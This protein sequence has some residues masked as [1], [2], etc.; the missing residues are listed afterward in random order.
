MP[1]SWYKQAYLQGSDCE[2]ITL[3]KLLA[4]LS[5]WKFLSLFTKMQY[6]LLIKN[7]PGQTPTVLVTTGI[8]E[9][10]THL[11]GLVPGRVRAMASAENEMQISR[12]AK[13]KPVSSRTPDILQNNV[14]SWETLGISTLIVDLQR[15][16]G[17]T[18]H[19]GKKLT[20]R[21]KTTPLLTTKWLKS[22]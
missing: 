17:A 20:G 22:F 4:C 15:T 14:R 2:S 8:R 7:L 1:T 9:E 21:C 11:P 16:A 10:K 6:N 13:R 12:R 18:S 3:K 5:V 19:Q